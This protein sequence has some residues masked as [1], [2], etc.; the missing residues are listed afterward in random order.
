MRFFFKTRKF[1]IG[2]AVLCIVL[3]AS[4]VVRII[5]G[6]LSPGS[7]VLGVII[8]PFEQLFHSISDS[9]ND[10]SEK[11][12]DGQNLMLEN[13]RLREEL[14][15]LRRESVDYD[16]TVRQNQFYKDYLE[17]KEVH[18]DYQFCDARVIACD[19]DDPYR[20]FVIN[21]GSTSGLK[22][23]DPVMAGQYLVGYIHS[24]GLTSA[25]VTTLLSPD[26]TLGVN[27]SRTDDPGL[28]TGTAD[29]AAENKVKLYNLARSCRVA[30]GDY[31]VSS[32]EGIFPAG[33]L[34]GKVDNVKN[35]ADSA[36]IYATVTPFAELD[37]LRT[38]MVITS[39]SGQGSLR[40]AG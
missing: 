34:V 10:F 23:H 26:I 33:L 31:I 3:V 15:Q 12:N 7:G 28:I 21:K 40:E 22:E 1:K 39:F 5:S 37:D 25:K 8:S 29:L 19:K 27:D 18:P 30:V 9:I 16:E 36:S 11:L 20:N 14:A 24:V 32:G 2:V 13:K 35:D 6:V 17:I 4:I 38:V